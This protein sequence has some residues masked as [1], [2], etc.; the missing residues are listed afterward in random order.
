[1]AGWNTGGRIDRRNHFPGSQHLIPYH[2]LTSGTCWGWVLDEP[3]VQLSAG[4]VIVFPRGEAHGLSSAPGMRGTLDLALYRRPADGQL[5]FAITMGT[6]PPMPRTSS[7]A[8][9]DAMHVRL[10]RC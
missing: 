4:D 8:I 9:W 1:M 10:I 7:A 6:R 2:V 3:P 5:P